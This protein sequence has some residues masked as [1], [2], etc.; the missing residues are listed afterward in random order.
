V[1]LGH[2]HQLLAGARGYTSLAS[3]QAAGE[4]VDL[5]T[6]MHWIVDVPQLQER[7]AALDLTLDPQVFV[8]ALSSASHTCGG[9]KIHATDSEM[10]EEFNEAVQIAALDDCGVAGQMADTNCTGPW[11]AFLELSNSS[12]DSPAQIGDEFVLDY[13]GTV[14]GEPDLE[15]PHSGDTVNVSAQLRFPMVGKRLFVGPPAISIF[16]ALDDS[17]YDDDENDDDAS[18]PLLSELEAIAMEL[19]VPVVDHEQL[20]GAEIEVHMTHADVHVGYLIDIQHCEPS[21]VVDRLRKEHPCQQIWVFGN[22]FERIR[23]SA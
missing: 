16:G 3:M 14:R 12:I 8:Q 20:D 2:A 7:A 4:P 22:T 18:L 23:R 17:Y 15:R 9:P 1:K 5:G 21:P 11:E 6:S 13:A 10:A 19:N